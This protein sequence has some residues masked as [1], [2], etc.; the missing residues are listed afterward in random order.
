LALDR[1]VTAV[2]Q[3]RNEMSPFWIHGLSGVLDFMP[4]FLVQSLTKTSFEG[5]LKAQE[6]MM[7]VK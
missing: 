3:R 5:K 4:E 2:R 7:K 1:V 6:Q